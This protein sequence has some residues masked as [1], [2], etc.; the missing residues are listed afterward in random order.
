MLDTLSRYVYEVYRCKSVSAAA[1]KL[2][3]SQPALSTS[4]KKAEEEL[5]AAIFNRKTIP[6]TLTPEGKIYIDAIEKVMLL[7][8]Q[9]QERIQDI[10]EARGGVLNIATSTNLSYYVIPKICEQFRVRYPH[11]DINIT[12]TQTSELVGMLTKSTADLAFL[13]T[14]E[15]APGFVTVPLLEENLVVA[16][17]RDFD[18]VQHLLPYALSYDEVI[19]RKIPEEKQ[20]RDM[21][22]FR[23]VDFFYSPPD[24]NIFKKRKLI[25]GESESYPYINTSSPN[26]RINYNLMQCGFGAMLTT[27]ADVATMSP[28]EKCVYFALKN[29]AAK[30][31]FSIAHGKAADSPTYRLVNE[32]VETAKEYF[33]C[34]NPLEKIRWC[35]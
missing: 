25:F 24:S 23:G 20:I 21:E 11:V 18:G 17:R 14:E 16:V 30:Q 1:K 34:E 9:T 28:N 6:F 22:V 5:G 7:E 8:R 31:S 19:S 2:Y 4:I 27:D 33:D 10:Y 29:P 32:F 12:T 35:V 3:L 13:P 26:Q 15:S